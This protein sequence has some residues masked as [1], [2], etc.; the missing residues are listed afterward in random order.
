M[1]VVVGVTWTLPT[2]AP[3]VAKLVPVQVVALALLQVSWLEP[4]SGM[5]VTSALSSAV[6]SPP[7]ATVA[8]TVELVAPPAPVQK[9][10]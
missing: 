8:F 9:T 3:P 5:L 7:T 6:T 10:E 1:V 2:T 4:P